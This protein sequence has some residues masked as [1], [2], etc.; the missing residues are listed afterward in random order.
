MEDEGVTPHCDCDCVVAIREAVGADEEAFRAREDPDGEKCEHIDEVAEI[1]QEVVVAAPLVRIE[2]D[3]HEIN[4]LGRV[5]VVEPL[6]M[7]ANEV[8]GDEDV[9]NT[10]NEGR[11]LP[12]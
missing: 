2:A 10:C 1:C 8:A 3:R 5:P 11:L 9:E 7:A 4:E 6:W 12:H